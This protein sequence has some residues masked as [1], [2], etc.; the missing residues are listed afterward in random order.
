MHLLH[1]TSGLSFGLVTRMEQMKQ[2]IVSRS[3]MH[4]EQHVEQLEALIDTPCLS[5]SH[6]MVKV[7]F[8]IISSSLL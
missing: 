6:E 1:N 8:A 4:W 2:D 3:R 7:F 5:A